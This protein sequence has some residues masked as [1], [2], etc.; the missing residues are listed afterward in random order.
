[1]AKTIFIEPYVVTTTLNRAFNDQSPSYTVYNN[2]VAMATSIGLNAFALSFGATYASMTEDQLSTRL[3]GNL[4]LLP[5]TGLQTALR[6]YLESVGKGN[7]GI[8]AMQLGQ[9]LS[10]LEHA[11]GDQAF[12]NAAA[13]AWNKELNDSYAYSSN[14]ANTGITIPDY[15]GRSPASPCC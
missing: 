2:Q 4:G 8:V 5:N 13:V 10:G 9:I 12:F 6:D 15:W 14:P 1:M 3:L 7:V 11:T